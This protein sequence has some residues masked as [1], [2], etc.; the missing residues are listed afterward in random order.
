MGRRRI[1]TCCCDPKGQC[2]DKERN[3]LQ[4]SEG[5][6]REE[7]AGRGKEGIAKGNTLEVTS[8]LSGRGEPGVAVAIVVVRSP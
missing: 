3:C 2:S 4:I 6:R 8:A 5:R 1:F 7:F